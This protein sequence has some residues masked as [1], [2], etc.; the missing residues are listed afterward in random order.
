MRAV[1][2][3]PGRQPMVVDVDGF[4]GCKKLLNDAYIEQITLF[5]DLVCRIDEDGKAKELKVNAIAT[6]RIQRMLRDTGRSLMPFDFLVGTV[7]IIGQKYG[8][9]GM[10][11]A[12]MPQH[13]IDKYFV[14]GVSPSNN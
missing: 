5:D 6:Q 12:D 7:I 1:V 11:D 14:T 3:E 13:L 9:D 10:E 4:D 2:I 8:D